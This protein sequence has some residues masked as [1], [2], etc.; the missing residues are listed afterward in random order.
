MH[1]FQGMLTRF[2]QSPSEIIV[3]GHTHSPGIMEDFY[4]ANFKGEKRK[5]SLIVVGSYKTNDTF[6]M[7]RYTTGV[8]GNPSI[9]LFPN[10]HKI[11]SFMYISD[12]IK[13]LEL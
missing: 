5:R 8:A 1:P 12:A 10:T 4:G 11:L 6:T 3:A 13:Y 2:Y 9:V 7:R